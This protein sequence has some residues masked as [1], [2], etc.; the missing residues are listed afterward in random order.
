MKIMFYR[1]YHYKFNKDICIIL[2]LMLG[3]EI[4]KLQSVPK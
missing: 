4:G 1:V 3:K 2:S